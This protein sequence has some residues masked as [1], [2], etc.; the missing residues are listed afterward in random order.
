MPKRLPITGLLSYADLM[1]IFSCSRDTVR[2]MWKVR[3]VIP[4]PHEVEGLGPRW[5]ED[6]ILLYLAKLRVD[7][8]R[9]REQ[10]SEEESG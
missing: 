8:R 2:R 1:E 5:W 10:A 3:K 7:S 6:D 9:Q 4:P